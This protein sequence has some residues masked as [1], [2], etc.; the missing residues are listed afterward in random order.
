MGGVATLV[1]SN[2]SDQTIK[3]S[4]GRESNE[5]IVTRHNEFTKPINIINI[6]GD[7][8]SRTPVDVLDRKWEEILQ[9]VS[10]I[11][12]RQEETIIIGDLN[13]PLKSNKNVRKESHGGKHI[14]E[15]L[16]S[17]EYVLVNETNRVVGGPYTIYAPED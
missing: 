5:F 16:E 1:K 8:E 10:K 4:E 12:A 15:L 7:N 2:N 13:K 17:G 11:E 14:R 3:I 6:Y 9:E